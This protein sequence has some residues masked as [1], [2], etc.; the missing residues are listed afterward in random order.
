MAGCTALTEFD[1]VLVEYP[2]G[3]PGA[4]PA[5]AADIT[6]WADTAIGP[7]DDLAANVPADLDASISTLRTALQDAQQGKAVDSQDSEITLAL[8]A[9]DRWGNATCGFTKL[10]VTAT[11]TELTGVPA[12]MAAGPVSISFT[13]SGTPAGFVLLVAKVKDGARYTLEGIR[14]DSI[15]F[16]SV[17]DVVAVAQPTEQVSTALTNVVL[18]PGKYLVVSPTGFPPKF[19]ATLAAELEVS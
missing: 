16:D 11:G 9:V 12:T 6:R 3:E 2:G 8:D 10:D 13:N 19:S 18:E 4:P 1:T 7:F 14:N 15:A 17:A 5:S